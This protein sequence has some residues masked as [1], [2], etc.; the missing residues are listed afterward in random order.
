M[1]PSMT[2]APHEPFLPIA[3]PRCEYPMASEIEEHGLLQLPENVPT[4]DLSL[5]KKY[6]SDDFKPQG[7]EKA[8]K[9]QLLEMARMVARS[10]AFR[11]PMNRHVH[12]PR[13][14]PKSIQGTHQDPFGNDSFGPWTTENIIYWFIRLVILTKASNSPNSFELNNDLLRLSLLITDDNNHPIG[15]AF[16]VTLFPGE[17]GPQDANPFREAVFSYMNPIMNKIHSQEHEAIDALCKKNPS[18]SHAYTNGKVGMLFMVARSEKLPS[19]HTFEL[20]A[21]SAEKF[22]KQNYEYMLVSA[23]NQWTGAACEVLR[24]I[25]IHFS[26]FRKVKEVAEMHSAAENEPYSVDGYISNK[27]SGLMFYI[28]KFR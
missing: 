8:E 26:P 15:G 9:S 2:T 14:R 11:E 1:D 13:K 24:G 17:Y 4:M 7:V 16:N 19:Q 5:T 23:S 18:F 22:Q 28:V 3:L 6:R 12:P 21:A 27:D 10:F 20:V 25:R